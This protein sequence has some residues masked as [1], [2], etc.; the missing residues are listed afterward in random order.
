M[1][2]SM[3]R[4]ISAGAWQIVSAMRSRP[5]CAGVGMVVGVLSVFA[6]TEQVEAVSVVWL[7]GLL[8]SPRLA[9]ALFS[10]RRA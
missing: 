7:A 5:W 2:K 6:C 10:D 9:L 8:V 1:F 4:A 3:G